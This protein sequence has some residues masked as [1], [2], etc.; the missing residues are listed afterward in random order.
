[1]T[2]RTEDIHY[3][4]NTLSIESART[5][6]NHLLVLHDGATMAIYDLGS[7]NGSWVR[8]GP[9]H[10]VI[11]SDDIEVAIS[12]AGSPGH[13]PRLTRPGDAEWIREEDYGPAVVQAIESW[14]VRN[15]APVS[16][17]RCA[18]HEHSELG[19]G[20]ADESEIELQIEGT[21][22]FSA[23]TIQETLRTYVQDQNA[24]FMQMQRRVSGMVAGST[25]IRQTLSRTADAAMYSRRLILLGPTGVG[26][27]LLARSYHNYSPRH[28][29]PFVTVNC[30]LLEK[31]LLYA[32]LFGARRG[33]F[34]GAIADIAGL[35]EAA[36]GG[37]LFMDELAEMSLDV[38]KALLR[39]LDSRGEYYRLGETRA[40]RAD[41]Q[42]VCATNVPLDETAFRSGRFRDDL[43][44]RL[45]SSVIHVPPLRERPDD[46]LAYLHSRSLHGGKLRIA[47]CLTPEA[48]DL[49]L[50]DSWP[51]NF[52]DLEN[53][54]D[55]LPA[56][57]RPHGIDRATCERALRE[58]RPREFETA[59]TPDAPIAAAKPAAPPPSSG[60][61]T[62][63]EVPVVETVTESRV[64][65]AAVRAVRNARLQTLTCSNVE[66]GWANIV[67]TALSAFLKDHGEEQIGWEQVHLLIEWYLK[68]MF[69]AKAAALG[70]ASA[71]GRSVNYSAL[72]RML[73]VADGSTVKTHLSR[74]EDRFAEA[75]SEQ[76]S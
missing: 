24:R 62:T 56:V 57:S 76:P 22:R 9:N 12:L 51:G 53:F 25:K 21:L 67:S 58:G 7:R 27:E 45:A 43:W 36:D 35:I 65:E 33:S 71:S 10:P 59:A 38:Q 37:T 60:K 14:L 70:R 69:V 40:R 63:V 16:V 4:L 55:R 48:L 18:P 13:E 66:L 61:P 72:A 54:V 17:R 52:R 3:Q 75:P 20:L 30:A 50:H 26:K 28:Q 8:L 31:E 39:F 34:T 44:F 6:A 1:M 29:G 19:I 73:N 74:F 23:S 68:P 5:S 47:E 32:Q 15:D 42:I 11:V 64:Q 2:P 41:V 49:V 46:I